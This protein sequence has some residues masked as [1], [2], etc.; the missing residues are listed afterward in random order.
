MI[1]CFLFQL[2]RIPCFSYHQVL[3]RSKQCF[4][5]SIKEVCFKTQ[6]HVAGAQRKQHESLIFNVLRHLPI[7][8]SLKL[9]GSTVDFLS[10]QLDQYLNALFGKHK[11]PLFSQHIGNINTSTISVLCAT[12]TISSF[13]GTC[14]PCLQKMS[15]SSTDRQSFSRPQEKL[16][17]YERLSSCTCTVKSRWRLLNVTICWHQM[18][19]KNHQ[20]HI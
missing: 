1:N 15:S 19:S 5:N 12:V 18:H 3:K 2:D 8:L 11:R 7:S 6:C 17:M 10:L 14:S 9:S 16:T 20:L 13:V 4:Y